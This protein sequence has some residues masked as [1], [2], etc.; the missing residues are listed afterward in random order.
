MSLGRCF[1]LAPDL[2]RALDTAGMLPEHTFPSRA[3]GQDLV[4]VLQ[5]VNQNTADGDSEEDPCP[6]TS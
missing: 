2:S 1:G 5:N 3:I 4:H 6:G